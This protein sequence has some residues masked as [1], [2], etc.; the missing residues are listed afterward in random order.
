[1]F[2]VPVE[3]VIA[4]AVVS[5]AGEQLSLADGMD[6]VA[7]AEEQLP[8]LVDGMNEDELLAEE[9]SP[10][11]DGM[12]EDKLL[13][14]ESPEA[15]GEQLTDVHVVAALLAEVENLPLFSTDRDPSF[16]S[17]ILHFPSPLNFWP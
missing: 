3:G 11:V 17:Q 6:D 2:D 14:G 9:Q 7:L 16:T 5:L 8:L 4:I 10:S 15:D 13:A 1:M 12:D